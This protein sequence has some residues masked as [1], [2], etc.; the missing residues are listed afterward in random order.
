M[1]LT[2][3]TLRRRPGCG[4][5]T[6]AMNYERR[7]GYYELFNVHNR[8]CDKVFPEDLVVAPLTHINL[9]FV[10]FDR[11]FKLID[12][13]GDLISRVTFLKSRYQGLKVL[14]AI[15]GWAFNDPPTQTLFSDMASTRPNR[16][17]FIISLISFINKY[18]LDGVD[19]DWEYPAAPDRGGL[20]EDTFNFV[21]LMS[22]IRKAFDA[23]NQ[24]WESTITVPTSYWYL[25]G[26]DITRL[27]D[28]VSYIN[29][30][31]Y[32]LHGMW[33]KDN[34]FTGP[35]LLGHTNITEIDQ[36]LDL[37]WR[38]D[39]R[40]N[41]VVMGFAFYGRSFTMSD[42]S[43]SKP[44]CTFATS[45]QPGSCTNEGGIL[46]YGEV[47]SRNTS[48]SVQTFYDQKSTVK[49]NV[50]DGNQWIS[51]DDQQS[52]FDKKKFLT[53]RCLG[54]LMIW[55][56]D[57]DNTNY[58]ALSGLLGDF[59]SSQLEGGG[60]DDKSAEAL[61]SAFGAY[62][63]QNC[64]VTPTCTD[65]TDGQKQKDQVCPSGTMSVS[66]AHSPLQAPGR[67]LNG[68]C[69][70]GW[71]RHIC[72]PTKAM[73]KNCKWDGAPERNVFGCSGS[74]SETQFSL[75][76]DDYIDAKGTGECYTGRRSLCC[77]STEVF[78]KC[79][80]TDC[81]G[82]LN[83]YD[84]ADCFNPDYTYQTFRFDQDN[85]AFCSDAYV[86]SVVS[87][88]ANPSYPSLRLPDS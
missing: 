2:V 5:D 66:T 59:S 36:G 86:S 53:S 64:F 46:S 44:G 72:C 50:Y 85:G 14:V 88:V 3:F 32:D 73:P 54:G 47:S 71:Y 19:I 27:Q 31:S 39:I 83:L 35:Y 87:A 68:R 77:D 49:Y 51:Y 16:Q 6:D 7:I 18:G 43:C 30:M 70:E 13:D 81:Q 63:G 45:G 84:P 33:D 24:A 58:D 1:L 56:I 41:N 34:E 23:T 80:W 82:P 25:R 26:F 62:T 61:S 40:P 20:P 55:A 8:L 57:Q 78:N 12:T 9:A 79:Y 76:T 75:N 21:L 60:L 22:E 42:P 48:L 38:N 69:D 37:L 10:L 74:C 65:G 4:Q 28:H 17:V 67:D 52:F 15:G 29:L 11:S